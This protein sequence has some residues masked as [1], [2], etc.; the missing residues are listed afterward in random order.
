M[1]NIRFRAN[2]VDLLSHLVKVPAWSLN[3]LALE[4]LVVVVLVE[5]L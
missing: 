4:V 1:V 5:L 3:H 2:G